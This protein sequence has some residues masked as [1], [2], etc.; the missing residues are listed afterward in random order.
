MSDLTELAATVV[1]VADALD[2]TGAPWAIG[3]SLA[4]A[5]HGEP[6]ATNDV[7]VVAILDAAQ[8]RQFGRSLGGTFYFDEDMA[9]EA[10]RARGS[11]NVI[12]KRVAYKIDVFVPGPGPLGSGQLDRRRNLDVFP[13]I[14]EL[15]VL[16]PEDIVLQKL[17]WYVTGGEVSDRQWRDIVSVLRTIGPELDDTYLDA[18]AGPAGFAALLA[19]ARADARDA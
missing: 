7:D 3:G 2:A 13:G 4:S 15:P 12:D 11:F 19:R 17:R 10:V 8:A 18:V 1:A 14:R 9:L 5:A 6:R 16:G